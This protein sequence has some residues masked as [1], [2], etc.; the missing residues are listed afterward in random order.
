MLVFFISIYGVMIF[1]GVLFLVLLGD[2]YFCEFSLMVG[3]FIFMV[4]MV[5]CV[6]VYNIFFFFLGRVFFGFVVGVFVLIVYVLV[7]DCVFY[8]YCGKVMGLIVLS[9]L[10]VLI[11][12]VL[13]GFFIGGVLN[14]WWIFWIFVLMVVFV[15]LFI[16]IEV[17]CSMVDG[18]KIEEE[19]GW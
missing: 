15:V 1:I 18:D 6:L 8:V 7:G 14:W 11:F 17:C 5:I 9:W 10:F 19:S 3:F 4:G 16:F 2:K 13:I 12:G